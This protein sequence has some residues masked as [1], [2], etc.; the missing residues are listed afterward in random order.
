QQEKRQA[1]AIFDKVH[2]YLS[3]KEV[4]QHFSLSKNMVNKAVVGITFDIYKGEIFGLEGESG[5][6]KSTTGRSIIGLHAITS[7]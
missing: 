5:C 3:L 6:G 7:G 2:P 1:P 4:K